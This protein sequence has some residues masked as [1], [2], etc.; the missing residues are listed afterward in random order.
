MAPESS[1]KDQGGSTRDQPG[2]MRILLFSG[3]ISELS[4]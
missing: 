3:E 2:Q 4:R 1:E